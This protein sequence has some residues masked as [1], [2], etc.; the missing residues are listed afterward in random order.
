M[1]N[2]DYKDMLQR[3]LSHEAKFLVVGAY[4]MAAQG[5]P[6]AT[7]DL[8]IWVEPSAENSKKVYAAL[9]E[10]GVPIKDLDENTF[11][12]P[13]IV[14]QIGVVPRRI[15]ILTAIEGVS[16]EEG[17][18][19]KEIIE[20][21]NIP[22]SFLSKRELIKNKESTGREKDKLDVKYLKRKRSPRPS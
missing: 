11:A 10:F 16:F 21:D 4:A 15:D 8:D 14:F 9:A 5:Y 13:G 7:G 1:L 18:A 6:R 3:L 20:V 19:G 12:E 17:Y 2:E 22:I